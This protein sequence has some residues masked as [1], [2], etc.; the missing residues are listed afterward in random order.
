ME[1][2]WKPSHQQFDFDQVEDL[3]VLR[4]WSVWWW[5]W[6]KN[7][8]IFMFPGLRSQLVLLM[9]QNAAPSILPPQTASLLF[10]A[11]P[12]SRNEPGML[13]R[14]NYRHT[15]SMALKNLRWTKELG[16]NRAL[17]TWFVFF[18]NGPFFVVEPIIKGVVRSSVARLS[19]FRF[20]LLSTVSLP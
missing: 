12:L 4:I 8:S 13:W 18:N 9:L 20:R 11:L 14:T 7:T 6:Y 17:A 10:A 1:S 3:T 2:S 16:N 15:W 19:D 5:S